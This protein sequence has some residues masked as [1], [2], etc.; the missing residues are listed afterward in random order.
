MLGNS[1]LDL[2]N[3][4]DDDEMADEGVDVQDL[5]MHETDHSPQRKP[6]R[7]GGHGRDQMDDYSDAE[8]GD[9]DGSLDEED[10]EDDHVGN[11]GAF[12]AF[13]SGA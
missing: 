5:D 1:Q 6:L 10:Y 12:G 9:F 11:H 8:I 3:G 7:G 13:H 2:E 4:D